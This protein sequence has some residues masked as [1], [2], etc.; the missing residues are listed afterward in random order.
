MIF[1]ERWIDILQ[2]KYE[3]A[4]IYRDR[5]SALRDIQRSQS[6]TGFTDNKDAISVKSIKGKIRIGI[7]SVNE[8]WVIGHK[9][10]YQIDSYENED[11]LESFISQYYL[12]EK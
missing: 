4:A 9:N 5:I 3:R 12:R 7:T 10:F 8:G 2:K 11:V 6:V 1:T